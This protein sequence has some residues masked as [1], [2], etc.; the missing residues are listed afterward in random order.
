MC[1]I[2]GLKMTGTALWRLNLVTKPVLRAWF[3]VLGNRDKR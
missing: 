1:R 2:P 3:G